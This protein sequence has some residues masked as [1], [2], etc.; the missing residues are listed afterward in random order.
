MDQ[1]TVGIER[2]IKAPPGA[3]F[4]LLTD[5]GFDG[6]GSVNRVQTAVR[7][8][9]G[10]EILNGDAGSRKETQTERGMAATLDEIAALLET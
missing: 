7:A 2:V 4:A 8:D 1:N 10:F 9:D 3:V 6:S 5:A